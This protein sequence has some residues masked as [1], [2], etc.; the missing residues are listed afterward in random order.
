MAGESFSV[1]GVD[2]PTPGQ[3]HSGAG[4]PGD[5]AVEE[6]V[7]GSGSGLSVN[8]HDRSHGNLDISFVWLPYP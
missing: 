8:Y 5:T 6:R 1:Q 4:I 3:I 2:G 7:L